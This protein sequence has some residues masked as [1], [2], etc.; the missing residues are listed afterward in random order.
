MLGAV[1]CLGIRNPRVGF[2]QPYIRTTLSLK[3]SDKNRVAVRLLT[4][5][6]DGVLAR[7]EI[8][9]MITTL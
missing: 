6:D 8:E 2:S 3:L 5:Q 9:R 7:D 4:G 1:R